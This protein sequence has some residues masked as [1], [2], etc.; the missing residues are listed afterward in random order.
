MKCV[1]VHYSEIGIKGENRGFFE[2]RLAENIN[3][4]TGG[5]AELQRGRIVVR[6]LKK[7]DALRFIPGIHSYTVAEEIPSKFEKI[8][9]TALAMAKKS[10]ANSFRVTTTRSD[11][12]FPKTSMEINRIVGGEIWKATKKKVDL[13]HPELEIFIELTKKTYV[14]SE[15]VKCAGGLP[16]GTAGK[17]VSLLSGG[18]DSPVAAYRM[19]TRGCKVVFV[20]FHNYDP[21]V[22]KIKELVSVLSKYQGKSIVYLVPFKE[23][24]Q[25]IIKKTDPKYRM[26]LYRRMMMK[27]AEQIMHREKALGL[28][29]GDSLAQ[30]ASQTLEN[31]NSIYDA[32][33]CNIYS[34]L[35]GTHK[36]DIVDTAEKIGT[37][38]IS[39][40]PYT[41]CCSVLIAKHPVIK[42]EVAAVRKLEKKL[43]IKKMVSDAIKRAE[44][45]KI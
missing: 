17:V 33:D 10:K 3:N 12:S 36:Q 2:R 40:K 38:K 42:S 29:T 44:I 24:Q 37:Y 13:H 7:P 41:D 16:V 30:V 14:Y 39:I 34:P 23:A 35:I 26:I 21:F 31:L 8:K 15:K 22:G 6:G 19:M 11:K 4:L 25:E 20:H 9:A 43:K 28:V 18:I 1:L 45:I 32:V 5:K 27:I